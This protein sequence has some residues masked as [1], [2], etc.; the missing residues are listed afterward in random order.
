[1]LCAVMVD[2]LK[3]PAGGR[4]TDR[5]QGEVMFPPGL[6]IG[7][8]GCDSDL[9]PPCGGRGMLRFMAICAGSVR[10]GSVRAGSVRAGSPPCA[11]HRLAASYFHSAHIHADEA[12]KSAD[13]IATT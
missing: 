4:G 13:E 6:P 5:D 7:L 1:M 12:V 9:T 11:F 10:A 8:P 3:L 2:R